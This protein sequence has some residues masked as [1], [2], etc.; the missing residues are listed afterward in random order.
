MRLLLESFLDVVHPQVGISL[1][2]FEA[3]AVRGAMVEL[4]G[5]FVMGGSR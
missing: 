4:Y 1:V 5:F 2:S 3:L